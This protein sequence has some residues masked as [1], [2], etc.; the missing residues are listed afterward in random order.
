MENRKTKKHPLRVKLIFNPTA[1]STGESP[2]QLMDIIKEM[3]AWNLVCEPFLI[4]PGCNIDK[5]V[6]DAIDQGIKMIVVCGGDGTVES[7][8]RALINKQ[9]ILGIIPGGTANN[10]ALSL[11]I[12]KDIPAAIALL[13]TGRSCRIDIG[14]ATVGDVVTPLIEVCSIGLFSTL[15]ASADDIQHG[16]LTKIGAFVSTLFTTTPSTIRFTPDNKGEVQK[17]GHIVLIT[18]MPFIGRNIQIGASNSYDDGLLDV[19]F[20]SDLTKTEIIGTLMKGIGVDTP[21]DPRIKRYKVR[22]ITIDT[23]PPMPIIIDN[24][25]IGEGKISIE[26]KRRALTVMTGLKP[27]KTLKGISSIE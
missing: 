14:I 2:L 26:V 25:N 1:G 9:A 13:R 22:K 17:T 11:N 19:L 12:P 21:D 5:V 15:Y 6:H 24:L 16:D 10:V 27:E 3:Q 7:V 18:N 20:F 8:A 4:E 23:Q